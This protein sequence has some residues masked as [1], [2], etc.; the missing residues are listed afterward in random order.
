MADHSAARATAY[1]KPDARFAAAYPKLAR[2]LVE[3]SEDPDL[4][5]RERALELVGTLLDLAAGPDKEAATRRAG[6]EIF[7]LC[8]PDEA[9]AKLRDALDPTGPGSARVLAE[10]E[11]QL[12]QLARQL[13]DARTA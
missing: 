3:V 6:V 5:K 1:G 8:A 13:R 4:A 12:A 11:A 10:Q 7:R 2:M 9:R